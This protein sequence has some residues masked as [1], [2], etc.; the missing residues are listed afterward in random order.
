MLWIWRN[1]KLKTSERLL[2]KRKIGVNLSTFKIEMSV[3]Q[4]IQ[5]KMKRHLRMG[6]NTWKAFLNGI[7]LESIIYKEYY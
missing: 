4:K 2:I 1:S 7:R 6:E 3:H 5:L